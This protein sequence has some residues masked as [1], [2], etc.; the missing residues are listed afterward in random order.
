MSAI[1]CPNEPT[2]ERVTLALTRIKFGDPQLEKTG[3]MAKL[4]A[5]LV[6]N[7]Y[8]ADG[9][10]SKNTNFW[11]RESLLAQ[12]ENALYEKEEGIRKREE[13][14]AADEASSAAILKDLAER[15][16]YLRD[17]ELTLRETEALLDYA[18]VFEL[19]R[20]I[21]RSIPHRKRTGRCFEK[22]QGTV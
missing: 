20:T 5:S 18:S 13:Q 12:R 1:Y 9:Q 4:E 6:A 11:D 17:R 16:A 2:L 8:M 10:S 7:S 3:F 22:D 15:E 21:Q 14:V 19:R